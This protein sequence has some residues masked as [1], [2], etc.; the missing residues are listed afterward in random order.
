MRREREEKGGKERKKMRRNNHG[1]NR[2]YY[3]MEQEQHD[4]K[5]G[6]RGKFNRTNENKGQNS[7]SSHS[8]LAT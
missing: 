7:K 5:K 6:T 3:I 8:I 4:I 1:S 2:S